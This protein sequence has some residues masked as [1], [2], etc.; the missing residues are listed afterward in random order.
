MRINNEIPGTN[1]Q[2]NLNDGD[3]CEQHNTRPVLLFIVT[4]DWYFVSHRLQLAKAAM[5]AGYQVHVACRTGAAASKIREAGI[6]V[7]P[8]AWKRSDGVLRS[9][10]AVW[11][12]YR[13][14]RRV[15][16]SIVHNVAL[17]P[18]LFGSIASRIA[19][20]PR[21]IN[22]VAGL[23]YAFASS[24]ARAGLTRRLIVA[25]LRLGADHPGATYLFQNSDDERA[26][27]RAGAVRRADTALIRG[28]GIDTVKYTP[29][30]EPTAG[31]F[32]FA[33]VC[34][35]LAIKGVEDVVE[36]SRILNARNVRHRLLLVGAPDGDNASSICRATLEEWGREPTIEWLGE[37]DDIPAIWARSH[38][39]VLASH[40]G[41]GLPKSLLE[42]AAS[43]RAIVATDVP[44]NR[45][46]AIAGKNALL[47]PPRDPGA[48][49]DAIF[50]LAT[51]E[52]LRE[53][54]AREG[55]IIARS[56]FSAEKIQNLTIALYRKHISPV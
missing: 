21:I 24:S 6:I 22:A 28:A 49:A 35:M 10:V 15:R 2:E 56:E 46:I 13:L 4:E 44:G 51:D 31:P 34:R 45:E 5:D 52:K 12:L 39:A 48:L 43:G 54:Y 18:I 26:L 36:A 47:V 20:V 3:V 40:G 25:A 17:K 41:E 53:A 16:P 55:L 42:A 32:T 50:T 11:T 1:A 9:M 29:A 19:S 23:G 27:T 8:I 30:P 37:R 14:V 38:L 33:V 7:H